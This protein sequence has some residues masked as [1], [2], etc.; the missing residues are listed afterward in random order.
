MTARMPL[1][2]LRLS[3]SLAR[4]RFS[5]YVANEDVNEAIR[6]V[7]QSKASL[8]DEEMNDRNNSS[9]AK[10]GK[11]GIFLYLSVSLSVSLHLS[12]LLFLLLTSFF[13][14]HSLLR[15]F[16]SFILS[17]L[18]SN[19]SSFAYFFPFSFIHS[20]LPFIHSF[21]PS[22]IFFFFFLGGY[23]GADVM[24]KVYEII[25]SIDDGS[26]EGIDMKVAEAMVLRKGYT[27]QHL[28]STVTE[29]QVLNIITVNESNTKVF[30]A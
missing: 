4:L 15:S 14:L 21:L 23:A 30:I 20:F 28:A 5:D 6:L 8:L 9:S 29:Y 3:Q 12:L 7:H 22:F 25:R 17:F 13:L 18:P 11:A 2:I 1:S 24:G 16:H 19:S 27:A 26:G 10:G